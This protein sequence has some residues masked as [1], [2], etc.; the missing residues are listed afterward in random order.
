MSDSCHLLGGAVEILDRCTT[1]AMMVSGQVESTPL[2]SFE[3][4]SCGFR[5]PGFTHDPQACTG[6]DIE[7]A[8]SISSCLSDVLL[9]SETDSYFFPFVGYSGATDDPEQS[10]L[11]YGVGLPV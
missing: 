5:P 6:P 10:N 9:M 8:H 11:L 1:D 3:P 4:W 2:I 7:L